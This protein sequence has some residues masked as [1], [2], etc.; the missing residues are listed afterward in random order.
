[1]KH[2][3]KNMSLQ[4]ILLWRDDSLNRKELAK[5]FVVFLGKKNRK[6]RTDNEIVFNSNLG[7]GPLIFLATIQTTM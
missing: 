5:G 3:K 2:L 7:P 6:T 1:M 4:S